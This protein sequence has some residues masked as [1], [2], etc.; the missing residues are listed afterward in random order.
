MFESISE[1]WNKHTAP[2]PECRYRWCGN[3]Y[4]ESR[5]CDEHTVIGGVFDDI[6]DFLNGLGDPTVW[7]YRRRFSVVFKP[8]G[9]YAVMAV[10][11]DQMVVSTAVL[12]DV[13]WRAFRRGFGHLL[14]WYGGTG[15]RGFTWHKRMAQLGYEGSAPTEV[16]P[17]APSP[18]VS[19]CLIEVKYGRKGWVL[20]VGDLPRRF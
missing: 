7:R 15:P 14:D 5:F 3:L 17:M 8:L 19:N 20:K 11:E 9:E 4:D 12:P 2:A 13:A 1:L 10:A 16:F 18:V 6:E